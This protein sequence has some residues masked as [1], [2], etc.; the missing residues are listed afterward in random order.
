MTCREREPQLDAYVDGELEP[1]ERLEIERH[2]DRCAGCRETVEQ[3]RALIADARR[4]PE[5]EPPADLFPAVRA[6]IERRSGRQAS[7][8]SGRWL[9]SVAAILVVGLAGTLAFWLGRGSAES[10]PG[11]ATP[12]AGAQPAA[13]VEGAAIDPAVREYVEAAEALSSAIDARRNRLAP[14]TLEILDKNLAIIDGAI[15]ELQ[16]AL[17]ADPGGRSDADEL[18]AMHAERLQ[19]LLRFN[20]LVS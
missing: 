11:G 16:S 2:L 14:E 3:T 7:A 8:A 5:I 20:E 17:E 6:R 12:A 10:V 1:Q 15:E 13:L 19:L 9:R 18:R 4:L